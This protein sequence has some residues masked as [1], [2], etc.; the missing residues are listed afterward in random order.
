MTRAILIDPR[1][2]TLSEVTTPDDSSKTLDCWKL[3]MDIPSGLID[4]V[5][6]MP[7]VDLI[8]DDEGLT[9]PNQRF[10]TFVGSKGLL[11]GKA[12]L[13]G[14]NSDGETISLD[15]RVTIGDL[16]TRV[17]WLGDAVNVERNIALGLM[18][19][20]QTRIN[21]EVVWQWSAEDAKPA[22]EEKTDDKTVWEWTSTHGHRKSDRD[23]A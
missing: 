18:N 13:T 14:T 23:L 1:T 12:I 6:I 10:F 19:R 22:T 9:E 2:Q 3:L 7:E 21:G 15:P 5:S 8:V 17:I 16:Q 4:V 11:S 20:P